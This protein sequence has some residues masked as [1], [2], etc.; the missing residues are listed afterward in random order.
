MPDYLHLE[1]IRSVR[2]PRKDWPARWA[3]AG[4]AVKWKGVVF[5]RDKNGNVTDDMIAERHSPI[6][7]AIARG[8]GGF[9]DATGDGKPPFAY[10]SGMGWV[11]KPLNAKDSRKVEDVE[12]IRAKEAEKLVKK[13]VDRIMSGLSRHMGRTINIELKF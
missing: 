11:R 3:A 7:K 12:T 4:R 6:W 9:R 8:M 5:L 13:E 1:R 2:K 10:G